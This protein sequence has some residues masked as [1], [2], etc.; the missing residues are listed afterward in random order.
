M[1]YQHFYS[2]VPSR[3]SLYNKID[4][5]DTFAHSAGMDRE[6]ILGELS[7]VYT[8]LLDIHNPIKI[9]R[10]EIP[11]VY[12]Q[13]ALPSGRLVHSSV[14]YLPT[15]FTGERSAYFTHSLVLNE[16]ERAAVLR[17]ADVDVFNR[18]MFITDLSLFNLTD[19]GVT[20]NPACPERAYAPRPLSDAKK[21]ISPYNPDMMKSFIYSLLLSVCEGGREVYFHLPVEDAALS[22]AALDFINATMG[23]LPYSLRERVSFASFVSSEAAYPGFRLKCASSELTAVNTERAL[24]YDFASSSVIGHSAEIERGVMLSGFIYSLFE[25]PK[26]RVAFLEFVRGVEEKYPDLTLDIKA[27]KELTFLFWGCS[28]FYVESS[29]LPDDDAICRLLDIYERYRVGL[30]AENKVQVYKCLAR[31]SDSQIAIPDSVF[32]RVSRLYPA[33]CVEAKAVALDVM[34]NLIHVD[35]MR[36]SLFCFI[37]RNY[38]R[39]TDEVKAEI[40]S[41]LSRV[42]YGGFLQSNIL[43]FFDL[44]FRREPVRTRNVIL[45]KLLLSIRTP[46]IQGQIIVFLDRHWPVFTADQKLKICNTILEMMPECDGLSA[47]MVGLLNRRI[48]REGSDISRIMWT[49]LSEILAATLAAGDG[50]LAAMFIENEG[51]CEDIALAH[52]INQLPGVEIILGILAAMPG[53]TRATKLIRAYAV[54]ASINRG[55]YPAF[56]YRLAGGVVAVWPSTLGDMLKIDGV[57]EGELPADMLE[58][59]RQIAI[60]P[61]VIFTLHQAFLNEGGVYG[62]DAAIAYADKN[63]YIASTAEYR[64]IADYLEMCRKCDLGDIEDAFKL[65]MGLPASPELRQSIAAYMRANA[66]KPESQDAETMV[67]YELM[68]DYLSTGNVGLGECYARYLKYFEDMHTEEGKMSLKAAAKRAAT[69]SME[70][71]ISSASEIANAHDSL[72]AMVMS[73]ES[74]LRTAIREFIE[75]YG[76]G[77]GNFL[78]KQIRDAYFEIE[79]LALELIEERNDAISTPRDAINFLFGIK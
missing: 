43:A 71:L 34:L 18:E 20:S 52:A 13:A 45:D 40:I 46:D 8:G 19:R 51:F 11:V 3:V 48:G 15:D 10:G 64:V 69:D 16:G 68:M 60:Y 63:P 28:G 36:D 41:N 42:F 37:T 59:F 32:S 55:L 73:E 7:A 72:A 6:F 57:A 14:K 9:R 78:K 65:A 22:D 76:I 79:E 35:L 53:A 27:L 33:E 58:P 2:R 26:I 38:M 54:A 21:I 66:Y 24:L 62:V 17:Q 4:G 77:S 47:L 70:L 61:A 1:A 31:Y 29:V 50:R 49:K 30:T 23:V 75:F 67:A 12:T 44:Y 5:F 56:I 25:Q 39:E 74:G